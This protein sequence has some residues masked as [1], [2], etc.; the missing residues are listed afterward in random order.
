MGRGGRGDDG[1]DGGAVGKGE[2]VGFADRAMIRGGSGMGWGG[3]DCLGDFHH[4]GR[5]D[6]FL[7]AT[8]ACCGCRAGIVHCVG[9]V[10]GDNGYNCHGRWAGAGSTS[11]AGLCDNVGSLAGTTSWLIVAWG[12][13]RA[14]DFNIGDGRGDGLGRVGYGQEA[15][16]VS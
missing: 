7:G 6:G 8:S 15:R 14:N 5:V 9:S 1:G 3:L 11:V 10:G 16:V 12:S 2:G 13:C 4:D